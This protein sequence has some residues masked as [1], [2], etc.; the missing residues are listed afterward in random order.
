[1]LWLFLSRPKNERKRLPSGRFWI[2]RPQI[3]RLLHM[4]DSTFA[5]PFHS[6]KARQQSR[7]TKSVLVKQDQWKEYPCNNNNIT[8]SAQYYLLLSLTA[9]YVYALLYSTFSNAIVIVIR[10][11]LFDPTYSPI[12]CI[13]YNLITIFISFSTW[14]E[15]YCILCT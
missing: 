5:R 13:G 11:E 3:I 15:N 2:L 14:L 6:S 10:T 7:K 1:M 8:A 12:Y 4:R 9:R